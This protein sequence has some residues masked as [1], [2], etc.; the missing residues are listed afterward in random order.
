MVTRMRNKKLLSVKPRCRTWFR[1][2]CGHFAFVTRKD[3]DDQYPYCAF[4]YSKTG[5]AWD[6]V[7]SYTTYGQWFFHETSKFDLVERLSK[8]PASI[9][10]TP[11]RD[12]R[13]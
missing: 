1:T 3:K 4:I 8:R 9:P 2:R 11:S 6:W 10:T 7:A 12:A 5:R 13:P